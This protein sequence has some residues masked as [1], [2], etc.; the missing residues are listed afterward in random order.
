MALKS[1]DESEITTGCYNK[2]VTK[3]KRTKNL[4]KKCAEISKQSNIDIVLILYDQS[5]MRLREYH[6]SQHMN[7]SKI[8]KTMTTDN[9]KAS[10]KHE[11][12][13]AH[14]SGK[15]RNLE[16]I[17]QSPVMDIDSFKKVIRK[18]E[19]KLQDLTC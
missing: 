6:T 18:H 9:F 13:L 10:F 16:T 3:Y 19:R 17:E 14:L 8:L 2:Y 4:V 7:L 1:K 12:Y 5:S 11:R 15:D